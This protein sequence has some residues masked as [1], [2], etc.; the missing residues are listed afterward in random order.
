[1]NSSKP[2]PTGRNADRRRQARRALAIAAIA[3]ASLCG[4]RREDIVEFTVDIPGLTQENK[5][6][7]VEAFTVRRNGMP[8]HVCDGVK[9]DTFK[10][11]FERKT[12][13]MKY[14]SMKIAQTNIR[15]LIEGAGVE[16]AFP[17][18]S[19]GV[20]GYLNARPVSQSK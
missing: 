10:F 4:C 7:I 5:D 20:A 3:M 9:T 1:M 13:T 17:S 14:D 11:D 8:P 2:K 15:M 18:N 19:T 16:V 12:L 6:K